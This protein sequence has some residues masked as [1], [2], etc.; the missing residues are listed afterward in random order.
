MQYSATNHAAL[1]GCATCVYRVGATCDG[2]NGKV[3]GV[4]LD[5]KTGVIS[6]GVSP[7]GQIGYVTGE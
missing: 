1:L 4:R 5:D 7:R 6:G 3:M 2:S